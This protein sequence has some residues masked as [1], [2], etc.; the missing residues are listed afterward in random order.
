MKEFSECMQTNGILTSVEPLTTQPLT[1]KLKG[2]YKPLAGS[3]ERRDGQGN[4]ESDVGAT[5]PCN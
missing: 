3:M 4:N 5:P 1:V 2:L